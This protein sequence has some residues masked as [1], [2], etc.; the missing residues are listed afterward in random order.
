V[1]TKVQRARFSRALREARESAGLSQRQLAERVGRSHGNVGEWE[2]GESAPRE[3]I[4]PVVEV[5]LGLEA[6]T[7]GRHLGQVPGDATVDVPTA[8]E[9]DPHLGDKEKRILIAA[10]EAART[11]TDSE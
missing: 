3:A 2:R 4:T 1:S 10:Y 7:L 9:L 6:G 5:A 8:I 11:R